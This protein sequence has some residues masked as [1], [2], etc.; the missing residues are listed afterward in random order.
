MEQVPTR[1][2]GERGSMGEEATEQLRLAEGGEGTDQ[3]VE[4]FAG[5]G[6]LQSALDGDAVAGPNDG[7]E[8]VP[9]G[10]QHGGGKPAAAATAALDED[11]RGF[12]HDF[13]GDVDRF[14][15]PGQFEAT[16]RRSNDRVII[17]EQRPTG[18]GRGPAEGGLAL[19]ALTNQQ[20]SRVALGDGAGVH[21]EPSLAGEEVGERGLEHVAE[22]QFERFGI[23]AEFDAGVG[24]DGGDAVVA[25]K[26]MFRLYPVLEAVIVG[27]L[28]GSCRSQ[29]R[30]VVPDDVG[31]GTRRG[32]RERTE[33]RLE[34]SHAPFVAERDGNGQ[35]CE[36][37]RG[38]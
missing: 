5:R 14:G 22:G 16:F 32:I 21:H 34:C 1:E 4:Q 8:R 36:I 25:I 19:A 26:D 29:S 38:G 18:L 27:I 30:F 2:P 12:V 20:E 28:G 10:G 37:Y 33:Q 23:A 13:F 15:Q 35:T 24:D 17:G 7:V 6:W 9:A 11:A 31:A 3:Q